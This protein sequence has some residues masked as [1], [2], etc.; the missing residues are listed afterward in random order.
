M[1]SLAQVHK[2]DQ[3]GS[4][5]AVA[6]LERPHRAALGLHLA[7]LGSHHQTL[8]DRSSREGLSSILCDCADDSTNDSRRGRLRV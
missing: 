8:A 4:R 3:E 6:A 7:G 1:L 2:Q 5:M